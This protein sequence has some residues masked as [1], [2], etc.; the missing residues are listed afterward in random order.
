MV[1]YYSNT[2]DTASYTGTIH[3]GTNIGTATL[4]FSAF[5][6][7]TFTCPRS[8][9]KEKLDTK[10]EAKVEKISVPKLI[11]SR[12]NTHAGYKARKEYWR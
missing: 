10:Q 1:S 11:K 6:G 9:P 12:M 3:F 2:T 4:P 5:E 8:E 7:F